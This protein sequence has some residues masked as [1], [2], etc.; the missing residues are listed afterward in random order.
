GGAI[1]VEA[2][3]R[4][5]ILLL[6]VA[7]TG[8]GIP[9]ADQARMF[10]KFERGVRQ[11]GTGLGLSLVKS[12]IG[13]HGGD[14]VIESASGLSTRIVCRLP[15]ADQPGAIAGTAHISPAHCAQSILALT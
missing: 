2:V 9:Q 5:D 13:L 6:T 15:V 11:S 7:D 14:V 8:A 1:S 4:K 10:E 3:R 12:L